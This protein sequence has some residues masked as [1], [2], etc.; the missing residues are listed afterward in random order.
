MRVLLTQLN[1]TQCF[2]RKCIKG[3][4]HNVSAGN[5]FKGLYSMFQQEM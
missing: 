4:V 1:N 5:V 3:T 2:N